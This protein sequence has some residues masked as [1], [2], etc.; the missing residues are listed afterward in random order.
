MAKGYFIINI[1]MIITSI[2]QQ[3]KNAHRYS[4]YID[5]KYALSLSESELIR[6]GLRI[7]QELSQDDFEAL[8]DTAVYDRARERS[9]S[10][11]SIRPR[12][13]WE[14]RSYLQR[15]DY[16]PEII[17]SVIAYLTERGYVNDADFARRWVENRRLLKTTSKR[18]LVQELRQKRVSSADIESALAT[19]NTDEREVLRELAERKKSKYPD[20]LKFMQYLARQG[21]N[22]DDIKAVLSE[23]E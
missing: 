7:K 5:G 16:E 21:Y 1:N 19:D 9:L 2:K 15:K 22:Y 14:L 13:E 10:Q 3:V 8:K 4:I 11:L 6:S 23:E 17:D 12:S 18:R 20:R